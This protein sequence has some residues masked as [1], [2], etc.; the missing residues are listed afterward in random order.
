MRSTPDLQR[1]L[2]SV[3]AQ[4]KFK[5]E[6]DDEARRFMFPQLARLGMK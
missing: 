3:C 5:T 1:Q 6:M 2:W 4:Y